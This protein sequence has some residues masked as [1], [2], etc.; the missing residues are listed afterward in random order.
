MPKTITV[1]I[2]FKGV[3]DTHTIDD[4][5]FGVGVLLARLPPEVKAKVNKVKIWKKKGHKAKH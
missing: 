2:T 5:K 3:P 4:V 1:S